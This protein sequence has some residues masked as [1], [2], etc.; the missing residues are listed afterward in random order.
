[1]AAMSLT[2]LIPVLQ[3]AVGP[4]ILVSG[5]GL[6]LLSFTNRLARVIDRARLLAQEL[7]DHE[8]KDTHRICSQI[9]ILWRRAVLLRRCIALGTLSVL[10]AAILVIVL[11][12]AHLFDIGSP[13]LVSALFIGSMLALIGSL[14]AFIQDLNRALVAMRMEID[15]RWERPQG[16]PGKGASR[17]APEDD[18]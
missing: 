2:E 17:T 15:D 11:F 7:R 6:L 3:V 16:S 18:G 9:E 12:V 13:A 8:H 14:L 5:V 1:M 4:V 10:L